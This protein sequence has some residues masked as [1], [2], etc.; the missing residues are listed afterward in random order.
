MKL[1]P[2]F[3]NNQGGIKVK[4]KFYVGQ[5]AVALFI[6]ALLGCSREE[7]HF[8]DSDFLEISPGVTNVQNDAVLKISEMSPTDVIVDV[9]GAPLTKDTYDRLM[10]LK[11]KSLMAKKG[12]TDLVAGK[13]LEAFSKTYI[14]NFV[15]Q[16]LLIDNAFAIG[17][18]STNEVQQFVEDKIQSL[19]KSKGKTSAEILKGKG[20]EARFWIYEMAISY[21]MDKLIDKE[22]PPKA[23]VSGEFVSEVRKQVASIN[24]ESTATNKVL[25]AKLKQRRDQLIANKEDFLKVAATASDST[26]ENPSA[27]DGVWGEFEF[28]DFDTPEFNTAVFS[29]PE[30]GITD[31]LEDENGYHVVKVLS[32]TPAV[33]DELGRTQEQEKRLLSHIYLDKAPLLIEESD[34]IL[35]Q[36]LKRQM[37]LQ[38]VDEYVSNLSTNGVN[39]IT[40]PHGINLF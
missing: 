22:I 12:M 25:K 32:I 3:G 4:T 21:I 38:A 6:M 1:S 37:Q 16:R 26:E 7:T 27:E 29:L 34:V 19:A 36:D 8:L 40:Y 10:V 14:K 31:V 18:V 5:V 39:K 20:D 35:T 2:R 33:K 24:A 28:G 13:E 17:V 15:A 11:Y 23:E 30:G 9:N